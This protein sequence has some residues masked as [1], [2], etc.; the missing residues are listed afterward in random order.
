[1]T[2][3]QAQ[4][5]SESF[6]GVSDPKNRVDELPGVGETIAGKL[7][8]LGIETISGLLY[9]F[10]YRWVDFSHPVSI[11]Q[12]RAGSEAVIQGKVLSAATERS[13]RR[14]IFVTTALVQDGTGAIAVVWF[15]QPYLE[16]VFHA[17]TS[18]IFAGKVTRGPNGFTMESPDYERSP[19]IF[20]IYG[21]TEGLTSKMIRRYVL[22]ALPVAVSI[23]DPLP[24]EII[25]DEELLSLPHAIH[26]IHFPKSQ[27]ELSEARKRLAFDELFFLSL[28]I[29][30]IRKELATANAPRV[31]VDEGKGRAFVQSL[32]FQLTDAQ[33]KAASE[34]LRDLGKPTPM[35]RLLNG[36]VGSGK[37][38]VALVAAKAVIENG[39]QVAWLAP[40]EILVHQ[41][42][43]TVKRLAPGL[44]IGV[45]TGSRKE[46]DED[47]D[48]AIGT[49]ALLEEKVTFPRLGLLI[50]DEQ[51]R[52]GVKQRARLRGR[53]DLVPH[54]LS[55]TATPIPRTLAL[56]LYGDLDISVLDELPPGRR[57]VRTHIV[58]PVKRGDAYGFIRD[59][60]RVGRQAF[61]VCPL[62]EATKNTSLAELDRKSAVAEY[63]KLKEKVF[64]DLRIGLLHGRMSGK[65]KDRVMK[66]FKDGQLHLLVSTAVVEVGIDVPNAA[67]M[68]IEGAEQFGLAQLHQL[69]GRV[70]RSKHQSYCL[71]FTDQWNEKIAARLK[72]FVSAKDGFELAE[73]DLEL[74]GPGELAGIRQSGLPDLKMASLSDITLIQKAREHAAWA[75]ERLDRFPRLIEAFGDYVRIRHLE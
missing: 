48:V 57:K 12:V 39:Y 38:V 35:N 13:P 14:R 27:G 22:E 26:A 28:R 74:R 32:P 56:S 16:R 47:D 23:P 66:E 55:M 59:Q 60:I 51:H 49:H 62:I 72:A 68:M 44:K 64:S 19:G 50:V 3:R 43:E 21:E 53:S 42:F 69:R 29:Q 6:R 65:E 1:M 61:V 46:R 10:P 15:N 33:R 75:L 11:G 30:S 63:E 2:L 37:T 4:G 31:T 7:S 52:F 70:G 20:P 24:Q 67:V 41:H 73:K 8:K 71:V 36:D 58:P 25:A 40:T 17:G 5:H 34:I 45:L 9:Y 18:W 54:L